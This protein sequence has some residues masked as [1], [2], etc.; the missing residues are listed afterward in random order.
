[1]TEVV[2]KLIK[3]HVLFVGILEIMG[4]E[5]EGEGSVT[6]QNNRRKRWT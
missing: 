2:L 5:R 1:V 4:R 3:H 6:A